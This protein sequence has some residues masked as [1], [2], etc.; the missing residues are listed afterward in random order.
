MEGMCEKRIYPV[1]A[2]EY[3]LLEEIGQGVSAT[4]YRAVCLPFKEVVAIKALDLEKCNS[5]LV[6]DSLQRYILYFSGIRTFQ[7]FTLVLLRRDYR[8]TR[9][10]VNS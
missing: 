6:C 8:C 2:G 5:N 1:T 7:L 3:K 4:V 9:G 10:C